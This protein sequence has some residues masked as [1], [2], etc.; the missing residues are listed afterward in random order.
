MAPILLE[1][2]NS[3]DSELG[4][5]AESHRLALT[6]LNFKK[7]DQELMKNYRPISMTQTDYKFFTKALTD[8]INR[9]ADAVTDK[10]QTGFIP[11][12]YSRTPGT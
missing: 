1:L 2:F 12:V 8:R 6:T 5:L 3:I 10:W 11:R 7:G 9:V 4:P